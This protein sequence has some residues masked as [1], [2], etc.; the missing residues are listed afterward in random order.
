MGFDYTDKLRKFD[1]KQNIS[2]P[3]NLNGINNLILQCSLCD[4]YKN[5]KHYILGRG[6]T[7]AD[8]MFIGDVPSLADDSSNIIFSGRSGEL[9]NKMV[10]NVLH[11]KKNDIYIT[12]IVKCR[13]PNN[14][15]I[16]P[17]EA[18]KC[19]NYLIKEISTINPKIVICLGEFSYYYLT[20]DR[21]DIHKIRGVVSRFDNRYIIPIFHPNFLLRN[22]AYKKQTL[23]DLN[24][25]K[26]LM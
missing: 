12:N 21:Q 26:G 6:N 17:I 7:N 25:I 11:I 18:H 20:N 9:L 10:E 16:E 22:S 13:T 19:R 15:E 3:N 4:L 2:L 1:L 5:K 23:E 8:L 14:R 24:T